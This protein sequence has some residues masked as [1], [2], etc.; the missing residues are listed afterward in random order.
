MQTGFATVTDQSSWWAAAA[1]HVLTIMNAVVTE[2][3]TATLMRAL[4]RRGGITV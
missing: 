2:W 4:E 1:I 3:N